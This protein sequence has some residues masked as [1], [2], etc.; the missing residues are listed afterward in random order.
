[1][2]KHK[3][4]ITII[5]WSGTTILLAAYTLNSLGFIPSTGT[6]YGFSNLVAALFLGIRVYAD[7]NWANVA[8][9]IFF[10]VVAIITLVR[11]FFF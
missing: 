3:P 2:K 7:R 1:M 4:I 8:L 11:Y 9:E 5:G 6:I 10:G